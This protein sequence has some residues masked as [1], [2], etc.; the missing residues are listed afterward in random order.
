MQH[1]CNSELKRIQHI[2]NELANFTA[3]T[4]QQLLSLL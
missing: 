1:Y 2:L 3:F 4:Q